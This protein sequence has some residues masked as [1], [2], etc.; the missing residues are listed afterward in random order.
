MKPKMILVV[1]E[2][3][4]MKHVEDFFTRKRV[5][6]CYGKVRNSKQVRQYFDERIEFFKHF[7]LQILLYHYL[8]FYHKFYSM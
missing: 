6:Q 2:T 5:R 3:I 4:T 8:L 1:G 7:C